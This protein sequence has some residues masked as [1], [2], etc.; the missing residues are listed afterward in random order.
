MLFI[1]ER[2]RHLSKRVWILSF[3]AASTLLT[4]IFIFY[5]KNKKNGWSLSFSK[6]ISRNN[7]IRKYCIENTVCVSDVALIRLGLVSPGENFSLLHKW[8]KNI[9]KI[10]K[11]WILNNWLRVS[12]LGIAFLN[13]DAIYDWSSIDEHPS[14]ECNH[15]VNTIMTEVYFD[16]VTPI[17]WYSYI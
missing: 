7:R 10:S 14:K 16:I 2:G 9:S 12:V 8:N 6:K 17:L 11:V 13:W 5:V 4:T 3:C 1:L 15:R